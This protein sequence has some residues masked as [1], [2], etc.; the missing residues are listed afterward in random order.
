RRSISFHIPFGHGKSRGKKAE[1]KQNDQREQQ[2]HSPSPSFIHIEGCLQHLRDRTNIF[3]L[4]YPAFVSHKENA[5]PDLFLLRAASPAARSG[6]ERCR[7]LR[8]RPMHR[9]WR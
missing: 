3:A 2:I 5:R 9:G 4:P 8:Y 6:A 7:A 1:E